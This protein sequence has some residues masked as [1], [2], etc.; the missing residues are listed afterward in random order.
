MKI[1]QK[2]PGQNRPTYWGFRPR[3]Y[4]VPRG[5]FEN[6]M[7]DDSQLNEIAKIYG[8]EYSTAILKIEEKMKSGLEIDE[9]MNETLWEMQE[10]F[11]IALEKRYLIEIYFEYLR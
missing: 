4:A 3:F 8:P 2:W 1:S 5:T 6:P 7:L 10:E 11:Y 9:A